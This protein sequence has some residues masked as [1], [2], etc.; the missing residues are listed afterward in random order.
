LGGQNSAYYLLG[1]LYEVTRIPSPYGEG[2]HYLLGFLLS[3]IKTAQAGLLSAWLFVTRYQ[4]G[5][6]GRLITC[7]VFS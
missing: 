7:S 1:F 3:G 5:L 6:L 2:S 4:D